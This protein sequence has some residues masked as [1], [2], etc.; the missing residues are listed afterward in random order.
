[1]HYIALFLAC[2]CLSAR[3]QC[4]V[5][6]PA[7]ASQELAALEKQLRDWDDA[8][9]RKGVSVVADERYDDLEKIFHTWQRCFRPEMKR[10][11][12]A[13]PEGGKRLHPVAHAG[14]RKLTD[15]QAVARWMEN[16]TDLWVQPKVDGVAVTL[17]YQKGRLIR[18]I[19]RGNGLRGEDWTAKAS[20]IAA[21]PQSVPLDAP[22]LVLQGELFLKMQ[23]HQQSLQGGSNA[24]AVVAGAMR[25]NDDLAIL[26]QLGLF[27][28]AWPD[29]PLSM[30][31]RNRRLRTAGFMLAAEWSQ[32]VSSADEVESWR[33]R[34]FHQKLPFATDGVVIH[35]A[36]VKGEHWMPGNGDWAVAWKYPP[37]NASTSVRSVAFSVGRTGKISAVLNLE[38]VQLDDKKISRVNVGSLKRWQ[39][40]NILPGD[41]VTV[42]LAGQGIPRLGEVTWRVAERVPVP[43]P[44]ASAMNDQTCFY[45]TPGCREQFLARLT[46]LS[47]PQVLN[48]QGISHATWQRLAQAG[49]LE[50]LFTWLSLSPS[51]LEKAAGISPGRA[52]ALYHQFSLCPQQPFKRWV[53]AL[54]VPLPE[55]ALNALSDEGWQ[56][57]LVRKEAGWQQLPGVGARLAQKI[58]AFLAAEQVRELID[59]LEEAHIPRLSDRRVGN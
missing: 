1:M 52:R 31:E 35:S 28:W 8:Y 27:I 36:P 2:F 17:H 41:R 26:R 22:S 16:K 13:L 32:P 25:R 29:G 11:E 57:L 6:T 55:E 15:K 5:W 12:P 18:L 14:V 45:L 21:I 9:Y 54:G 56:R 33:E 59:W 49:L 46:W 7:R 39:Q 53:K 47:S 3:A 19:S 38:P 37:V 43:V 42:S 44:D 34:W 20:L 48:I 10:R 58:T 40:Q 23:D 30:K 4:P 51:A 24:R 50:H